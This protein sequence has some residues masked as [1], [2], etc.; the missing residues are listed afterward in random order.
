MAIFE[1][2]RYVSRKLEED[3]G[4][5]NELQVYNVVLEILVIESCEVKESIMRLIKGVQIVT[6]ET[7]N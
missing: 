5:E 1:L 4:N 7:F 3:L 2:T 6:R